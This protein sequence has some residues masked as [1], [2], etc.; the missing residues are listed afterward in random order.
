MSEINATEEIQPTTATSPDT[1]GKDAPE[2]GKALTDFAVQRLRALAE[3]NGIDLAKIRANNSEEKD[4]ILTGTM[5]LVPKGEIRTQQLMGR[6]LKLP[7]VEKSFTTFT[8]LAAHVQEEQKAFQDNNDWIAEVISDLEKLPGK[9]WG[10]EQARIILDNKPDKNFSASETCVRCFGNGSLTCEYCVGRGYLPCHICNERGTENC[11]NCYGTGQ[12]PQDQ[13]LPCPTC[14]GTRLSVCRTCQGRKGIPCGNCHAN[15]TSMCPGCEG[16]G[17]IVQL[18]TLNYGAEASFAPGSGAELPSAL[19]RAIDR[20]GGLKTL[21]NGHAIIAYTKPSDE[22]Q[23]PGMMVLS[24]TAKLRCADI[25]MQLGDEPKRIAIFGLK[26]TML[27]VP[28]FLDR[29]LDDAIKLLQQASKG[30]GSFTQALETRALKEA[31]ELILAGKGLPDNL[32]KIYPMGLSKNTITLILQTMRQALARQTMA[33]RLAGFLAAFVLALALGG[34]L[35]QTPLHQSL[36]ISA[37]K[38]MGLVVEIFVPL[39]CALIGYIITGQAALFHLQRVFPKT[40]LS[41][42]HHGGLLAIGAAIIG[43]LIPCAMALLHPE[44]VIWLQYIKPK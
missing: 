29:S 33:A 1:V 34:A 30:K 28:A 16:G 10:L 35:Y 26:R 27:E 23:K 6:K 43:L 32:R 17:K 2:T 39:F 12:N 22:D 8:E 38:T 15:G 4:V 40:K 18:S 25:V 7:A 37:G 36:I 20:A 24:Y 11:Y 9:G 5:R 42:H 3:G 31:C 13:N 41:M 19:R 14:N 44:G 21:A